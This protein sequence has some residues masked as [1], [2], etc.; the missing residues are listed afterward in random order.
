MII[1]RIFAMAN[2]NTFS[3]QPI[4][5]F[6][7]KYL[8][9]STVSIDPFA[10]DTDIATYTNDLNPETKAK[11]HLK[12]EDFLQELVNQG[13][14]ADLVIFDPP[15]SMEQCKRSYESYGYQFTYE[16]SL[17]VIRW[18]KEKN[19]I[20]KLLGI[21]GVFLHFGGILTAWA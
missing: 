13:V 9:K 14:K 1:N 11:Y 10:R 21:G 15:Y 17:Y 18:T 16:D 6:V 2:L 4:G 20:S 5:L 3:C 7:K 19:L 8:E 12:A